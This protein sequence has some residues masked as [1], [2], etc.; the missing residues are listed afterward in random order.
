MPVALPVRAR[1]VLCCAALAVLVPTSLALAETRAECETG[2]ADIRSALSRPQDP[3][4]RT[5]LE[6]ALRDAEREAGE[7]EYDECLEAVED[8][9]IALASGGAAQAPRRRAE[10]ERIEA[11][12]GLPISVESARVPDPG[13]VEARFSL[14]YE[15]FRRLAGDDDDEGGR[16]FGRDLYEAEIEMELGLAR[17]VAAGLGLSYGFGNAEESKQGEV[18]LALKWNFWESR[19]LGTTLALTGGVGL[20]YGPRHG[21]EETVLGLLATQELGTGRYAPVLHA[22]LTWFHALDRGEEERSDRYAAAVALAVPVTSTTGVLV[23]YAREQ[24]AEHRSANQF[25]ELGVRQLLPGGYLLGVGG[26]IGV[27]DSETDFRVLVGLLK[28]F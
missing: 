4:T 1:D 3:G 27:G 18:E 5:A 16:R 20:P 26:G 21:S 12:E 2:I 19:E 24:E 22:N 9:R 7:R 10:D 8:A 25:V 6:R 23:G 14:G 11:E 13:E 28:E 15:R 17:G